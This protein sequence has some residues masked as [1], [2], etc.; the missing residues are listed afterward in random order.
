ML[1]CNALVWSILFKLIVSCRYQKGDEQNHPKG[2]PFCFCT[3]DSN[4]FL[5][6]SVF[7]LKSYESL[8]AGANTLLG[9]LKKN[10][11]PLGI[12]VG[13]LLALIFN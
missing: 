8:R 4:C 3:I 1:P 6:E 13:V 11:R 12:P 5:L 2:T 10:F 9:V 7:S